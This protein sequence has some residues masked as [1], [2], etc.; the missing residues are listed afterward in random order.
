MDHELVGVSVDMIRGH[1]KLVYKTRASQDQ[2]SRSV[3][4][5]RG[6]GTERW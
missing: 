4:W 3:G 6:L 1:S 2:S 5:M